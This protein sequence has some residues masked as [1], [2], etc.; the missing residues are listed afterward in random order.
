VHSAPLRN[1]FLRE[2]IRMLKVKT[3]RFAMTAAAL[4]L[5]AGSALAQEGA[6]A[7]SD[8]PGL[9]SPNLSS[10][11]WVIVFFLIV[12][13]IL[14]KAAWKNVLA[15]LKA[16]EARIRGDIQN[17]EAASAKA[18]V[19]LKEYTARLATA[20]KQVQDMLAKAVQQAE[21]A[22]AQIKAQTQKENDEARQRTQRELESATRQAVT[23]F[24]DRAADISTSIAEKIIRRTLNAD[25]QRELVNRSLE[26]LQS[27]GEK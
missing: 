27:V 8:Q 22:A 21:A 20:E 17:A 5:L 9:V 6:P 3:S 14:Y 15:G 19:T 12:L 7:P 25:D 13:V 24:K 26:Q 10:I 16:R 4:A 23:D 18:E 1:F 2:R 11:V